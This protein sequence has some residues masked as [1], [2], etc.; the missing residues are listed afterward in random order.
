[1]TTFRIPVLTWGDGH[2]TRTAVLVEETDVAAAGSSDAEC[3]AQLKEYLTW[4]LKHEPWRFPDNEL[5]QPEL[6]RFTVPARPEYEVDGRRYPGKEPIRLR[7]HCVSARNEEGM[8]FAAIPVLGINFSF[9]DAEQLGELVGHYV[10]E[11]LKGMTPQQLSRCLAPR[12]V[13][14]T[15]FTLTAQRERRQGGGA[16]KL[17]ALESVAEPLGE[18]RTARKFSRAWEREDEISD[19]VRRI[20]K[21]R[22]SVILV[23]EPGIGKT[24][25]LAAAVREIENTIRRAHEGRRESSYW[26]TA[27]SR[28]IAGMQ[29]L[30]QWEERCERVIAE[31]ADI[32][33]VLCVRNLLELVRVGGLG[34][35]DSLAAFFL[36][37]LE[38]RELR[39]IC[40]ATPAELDA[41]RLILPGLV[42]SFQILPLAPFAETTAIRVL[43]R[44]AEAAAQNLRVHSDPGVPASV[45]RL[46]RRFL[47]YAAF[48]G[49]AA[50]FLRE[51]LER[52]GERGRV[53]SD[54][55]V[56]Q[57]I[58]QTGL[59]EAFLRDEIPL[60]EEEVRAQFRQSV[61]GQEPAIAVAAALVTTFKAGLNDPTRPVGVLLFCGPTGVGKTQLAK[62][63]SSYFFGHGETTERLLRLDM[64]EYAGHGAGERLLVDAEGQPS[65][66]LKRIRQQPFSVVLLDE[67]EKASPEVFDVLMGVFDEGRLTDR[68]GRVTSFHSAIV[69]MTSNLGSQ[70]DAFIGFGAGNAPD[71]DAEALQFFRPE[72]FNRFDTVVTF[73]PLEPETIRRIAE[74]E[75]QALAGR[76]GFRKARLR[77]TWTP[78]LVEHIAR[79]GFDRLYGARPL[80]RTIE[81]ELVTPLARHLAEHPETADATVALDVSADGSVGFTVST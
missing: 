16:R 78:A 59:P 54:A 12:D 47:P 69:V 35:G 72:F 20:H 22:A 76:E 45:Y 52:A 67:V 46:Y 26:L 17:P 10:Q 43:S 15:E 8:Y 50:H 5:R 61:I 79:K 24:S 23:G 1:M 48:P 71:Y 39:L 74:K 31:L 14:L 60:A 19:L 33:G 63:I 55:V 13:R 21:E 28:L 38:H 42:E 32:D 25:V 80:Q 6:R 3:L 44:I 53:T 70:R 9:Y 18:R 51:L 36:P 37:Y 57:F 58:A 41:C 65:D 73:R 56:R 66:F 34:A 27:A 7:V 29:Y 62:A 11:S 68:Y 30:G 2:G 81:A 64:S 40:E 4:T 75:L 49:Q 77:L